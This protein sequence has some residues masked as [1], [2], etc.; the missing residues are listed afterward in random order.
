[1]V[2]VYPAIPFGRPVEKEIQQEA[3]NVAISLMLWTLE[4][5]P[6]PFF[7]L[8]DY[9]NI[10]FAK[11]CKEAKVVITFKLTL[12]FLFAD[13]DKTLTVPWYRIPGERHGV[14]GIFELPFDKQHDDFNKRS[15]ED[16]IAAIKIALYRLLDNKANG[17]AHDAE[18]LKK[19]SNAIREDL[20]LKGSRSNL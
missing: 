14:E 4:G 9:I 5:G 3:S 1:M 2:P 15:T 18:H 7:K 12:R 8:L 11:G 19:I 6:G 16:A 10:T 20:I 13:P 17:K